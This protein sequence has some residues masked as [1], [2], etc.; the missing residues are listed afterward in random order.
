MVAICEKV[1]KI[2]KH[3]FGQ[4]VDI[5]QLIRITTMAKKQQGEYESRKQNYEVW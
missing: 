2:W 1:T 3:Q 5:S 4:I